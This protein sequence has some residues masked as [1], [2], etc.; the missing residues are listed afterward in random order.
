M[1]PGTGGASAGL[2]VGPWELRDSPVVGS[3]TGAGVLTPL[4]FPVLG[5]VPGV[6]HLLDEVQ[7]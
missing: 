4:P 3:G 2:T 5:L 7:G 6:G 1:V